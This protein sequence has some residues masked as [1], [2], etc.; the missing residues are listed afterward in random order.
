MAAKI[1]MASAKSG[2][3]AASSARA[4]AAI[5]AEKNIENGAKPQSESWHQRGEMA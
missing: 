4:A 1:I 3:A 5:S 2:M